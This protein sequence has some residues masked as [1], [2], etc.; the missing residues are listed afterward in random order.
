MI[1]KEENNNKEEK[2]ERKEQK[3]D[4]NKDLKE[5]NLKEKESEEKKEKE[6]GQDAKEDSSSEEVEITK[7]VIIEQLEEL[8][9]RII[10]PVASFIIV[11]LGSIPFSKKI[12]DIFLGQFKDII[13]EFIFTKPFESFWAHVKISAYIS[14]IVSIPLLIWQMW[15]FVSPALYPRERKIAKFIILSSS[16]LFILGSSFCFFIVLP[17]S[18][19]FLI[20]TFSS[21]KIKA[22]I[23]I[24]EFLSFALKF[25]LLFG[26]AF[27][28]PLIVLAL[29]KTGI[30]DINTVSRARPYIIVLAFVVS[31][32]VTPTPDALTQTLLAIPLIML[33]E[34]G[35]L[36]SKII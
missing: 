2:S 6:V 17:A 23:S 14:A 5:K 25:S 7:E 27:Q 11:F 10:V 24:S 29:V 19:K 1:E 31:A 35:V 32:I 4:G 8:R 22:L 34:L 20:N 36:I 15:L 13:S 30:L 28:T 9:R 33:W 3:T 18:L 16:L 12:M 21:E 26:F